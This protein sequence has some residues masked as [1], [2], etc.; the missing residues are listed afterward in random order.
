MKHDV[1]T[2]VE[3]NVKEITVE[4]SLWELCSVGRRNGEKVKLIQMIHILPTQFI[5]LDHS[6]RVSLRASKRLICSENARPYLSVAFS[7]IIWISV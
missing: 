5:W 6:L 4:F 7:V 1:S 2:T 3:Q